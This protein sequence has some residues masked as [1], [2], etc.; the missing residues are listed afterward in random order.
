MNQKKPV[1]F[2]FDLSKQINELNEK[3]LKAQGGED[4]IMYR[5]QKTN[6][7]IEI[8][9]SDID[10][11][12]ISPQ[13][14]VPNDRSMPYGGNMNNRSMPSG[15]NMNDRSMPSGVNMNDRSMPSGIPPNDRSIPAGITP[16]GTFLQERQL[17]GRSRAFTVSEPVHGQKKEKLGCSQPASPPNN[18]FAYGCPQTTK[19][20]ALPKV[21]NM[22]EEC[23]IS[24]KEA[25]DSSQK[26]RSLKSA[27]NALEQIQQQSKVPMIPQKDQPLNTR[28][29]SSTDA[30][31]RQVDVRMAQLVIE[32]EDDNEN[33]KD[34]DEV[35]EVEQ[36]SLPMNSAAQ[37]S[38]QE[39]VQ[40]S[41]KVKQQ[42]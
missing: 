4:A 10:S 3:K 19:N 13:K 7:Q 30:M 40:N 16:K 42:A 14:S 36:L 18:R 15:V 6:L 22:R 11:K 29:D 39:C 12:D 31:N 37:H 33:I 41:S 9:E 28:V 21:W 34:D 1:A 32:E 38:L 5:V 20:A 8:A 27:R 23:G 25:L 2:K 17:S 35:A 24:Q 26:I